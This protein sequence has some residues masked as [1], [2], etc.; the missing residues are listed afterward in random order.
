M[1]PQ[2]GQEIGLF[3][4]SILH[5]CDTP[6][7]VPACLLAPQFPVAKEY[8]KPCVI[9]LDFTAIGRLKSLL[10]STVWN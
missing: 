6:A 9:V 5:T 2:I 3:M 4:S 1:Q 10:W 7:L 8:F